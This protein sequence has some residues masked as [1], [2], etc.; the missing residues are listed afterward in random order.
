MENNRSFPAVYGMVLGLFSILA[1]LLPKLIV[2]GFLA[3]AVLVGVGLYKRKMTFKLDLLSGLFISL[4]ILYLLYALFTRHPDLAGRY[5]ENK[6][7][8]IVLPILFSFRLKEKVNVYWGIVGFLFAVLILLIQS[9]TAAFGCF[10]DGG[11]RACFLASLFSY[12]HHPSYTSVFLIFAMGLLIY[13]YRQKLQGF[14]LYLI[15][16][17]LA[18]LFISSILCLSLAGI[19]FLFGLIAVLILV[20]IYKKWGKLVC[21]LAGV[22]APFV[23]YFTIVSIPQVEGEWTNAKWYAD[24]YL[25]DSDAFI[26]ARKYPMSGTEVRIV[27]WTVSTKVLKK[28]PLG[29]GTGNVDEVLTNNLNKLD[30]KELAKKEYNPH[31]QFLQTGIEIGWIGL[32]ILLG[33]VVVGIF[34]SFKF[35][36]WLLL[37][38]ISNFA[39]NSLF[40]SMLQRQSGIVV[41]TFLICALLVISNNSLLTRQNDSN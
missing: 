23:L 4:Y 21:L 40:E 41:Y 1:I 33:I 36:N 16:P 7:S 32:L 14:K 24:E 17:F 25:K 13:G 22:L 27:M 38:I 6:L 31:N 30:Q 35:K 34:Y 3:L 2:L 39:F 20:L 29:V 18:L 37:L 19:L 26:K 5:I 11:G 12:Q 10:F 28:Y 9:Y 15:I 8:F